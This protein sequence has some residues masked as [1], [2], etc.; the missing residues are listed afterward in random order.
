MDPRTL[1]SHQLD[2]L[3][4]AA[5]IGAGHAATALSQ[6]TDRI[7]M[8]Q[9]PEVRILPLEAVGAMLGDPGEVVCAVIMNLFGDVTGRTVQ[10]FPALTAIRLT[11]MLL[12]T[13]DPLV[14][15]EFGGLE[16]SAIKEIGNILVAA[17]LNALHQLTGL[18]L[19][20]SAPAFAIDMAAAVLTT[21]YLNFGQDDDYVLAVSTHLGLDGAALPAHFLLIPDEPSLQGILQ[22]LRVA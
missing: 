16:R 22:A 20:M 19:S 10:V 1:E 12:R 4:E 17:Y 7:I 14:P 5:N 3:R 2:A 9:V 6:I 18:K 15:E 8:V 21:S 11:G 13:H